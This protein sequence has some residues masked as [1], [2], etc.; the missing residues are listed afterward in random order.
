VARAAILGRLNWRLGEVVALVDETPS[1][2][3][4]LLDVPDWPG[5]RAGQHVHLRL[6]APSRAS[7]LVGHE[8]KR[9]RMERFGPTGG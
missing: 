3:S 8:G 5:H 2:R 9:I 4:I 7:L 1:V 6:P